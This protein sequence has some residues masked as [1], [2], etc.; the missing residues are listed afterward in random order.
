ML[1]HLHRAKGVTA[2]S[3]GRPIPFSN[4]Y[5]GGAFRIE[6]RSLPAGEAIPQGERRWVTPD[7]LRTLQIRLE[8]GRFFG[9]LDRPGTE[10]VVVIDEKLARQYWPKEDPLGKRIQPT[11]GEGWYTIVGIVGHVMQ[12]DLAG[13]TGRGVF[14]VSL[15]QRPMPMGSILVKTA[16][17]VSAAA[18]AMRD[19]VRAA[20]PSLPLYDMKIM[21][22]LLADSLSPRRFA[23]RLLGLF[24]AAALFLAA[25][26]LYGV[27]S[28]AVTQ[29]R[30]E[31]GIRIALGAERGAVMRLVVGQGLR[32]AGTGVAIGIVSAMLFGR[33]IE[34]QLFEVR[35]LD[36]VTI[37]AMVLA[38]MA[39]TL[40]ASWLPARRAVRVDPA[41]TLRYE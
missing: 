11:S 33:L 6:G 9:D 4:D 22:A 38:L 40:L 2:A 34:S 31:I 23:M 19:A 29:R 8:R 18:A 25:L 36:P 27:L 17:D 16:G 32:L 1:D 24:A 30:R 28:Y 12:S 5:E 37:G 26:G 3:I 15:Y 7:Y 35:S 13:D 21:E 20:D 10:P 41:I 14:Y 39:A